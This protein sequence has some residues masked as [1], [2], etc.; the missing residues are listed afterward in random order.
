MGKRGPPKK[1]ARLKILQ[2]NPGEHKVEIGPEPDETV[3]Q[4]P[5]LEGYALELWDELAVELNRIGLL[6]MVDVPLF[7]ML[8]EA[9]GQYRAYLTLCQQAGQEVASMKGYEKHATTWYEKVLKMAGRFGLSPS[10]RTGLKVPPKVARDPL[11]AFLKE[12]KSKR[13]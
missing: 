5:R 8:C 11:E 2:G 4:P 7:S 1:A 3:T 10:D 12:G 9:W 13:A 6:T